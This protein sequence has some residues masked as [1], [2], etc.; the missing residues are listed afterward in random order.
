MLETVRRPAQ[1]ALRESRR[2]YP[3][4]PI[5]YKAHLAEQYISLGNQFG[6]GWFLTGEM[7]ALLEEGVPNIVCIQPFA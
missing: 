7:A 1:K 4:T 3:D 5:E 6:E 2:F